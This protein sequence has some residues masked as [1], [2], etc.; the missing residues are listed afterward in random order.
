LLG[1]GPFT[2]IS[3]TNHGTILQELSRTDK[4]FISVSE[5]VIKESEIPETWCDKV[6]IKLSLFCRCKVQYENIEITAR[7]EGYLT[8]IKLLRLV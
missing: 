8:P 1:N 2:A 3:A 4:D 7:Q 5:E 6:E